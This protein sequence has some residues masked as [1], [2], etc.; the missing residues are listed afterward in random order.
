MNRDYAEMLDAEA[1]EV[2]QAKVNAQSEKRKAD[3]KF[4]KQTKCF[5]D[6]LIG[7]E[8]IYEDCKDYLIKYFFSNVD[9]GKPITADFLIGA[10][11]VLDMFTEISEKWGETFK[12]LGE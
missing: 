10:R 9:F 1:K 2:E 6:L 11:Y 5:K 8:E 4:L 7:R 3:E 12:E